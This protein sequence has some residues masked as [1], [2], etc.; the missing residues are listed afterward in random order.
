MLSQSQLAVAWRPPCT[1]PWAVVRPPG[2]GRWTVR[3]SAR[4]A[5]EALA[6]TFRAY[7]YVTRYADTGAYVCRDKVG[8]PG[9]K[10]NHSYGTAA[11]S[12]WQ[13]G[14]YGTRRTDR[15]RGL[16]EAILRIRTKNGKQVFNNGIFWRTPD[17]MH[18]EVVCS[19]RDLAYGIDWST[20]PGGHPGGT[21]TPPPPV[22]EPEPEP[23]QP[24]PP[25]P[26]P[27]PTED[28]M[29][30][31]QIQNHPNWGGTTWEF[32]GSARLG[33]PPVRR[34]IPKAGGR[35]DLMVSLNVATG[36]KPV[37]VSVPQQYPML[38]TAWERWVDATPSA[39]YAADG[40]TTDAA[41]Q[42]ARG[43]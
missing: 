33:E 28:E 35:A 31:M 1:G 22:D 5:F 39:D 18:D 21:T 10:S 30:I 20:V 6:Q 14:P 37:L 42:R 4:E 19:P 40:R 24:P 34:M 7:G 43:L 26:P 23:E 25:P 29:F 16:N 41:R 11:D 27:P 3:A 2:A 36:G 8:R 17:P 15:P 12:N 32:F 38:D 9:E 13:S